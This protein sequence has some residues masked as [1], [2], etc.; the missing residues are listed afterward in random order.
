MKPTLTTIVIVTLMGCAPTSEVSGGGTG[1]EAPPPST[2]GT[3]DGGGG[4]TM[5]SMELLDSDG[6]GAP[7][8]VEELAGTDPS[9]AIDNPF[10]NGDF[11]FHVPL[12]GDPVPAVDTVVM[13]TSITEADVYFLIDTSWSMQAEIDG[14]RDGLEGTIMPGLLEQIPDVQLGAGEFDICP[15]QTGLHGSL[16]VDCAGIGNGQSITSDVDSVRSALND[17]TANC[18]I[19][20]PYGQGVYL[21]ATGDTSRW[22]TLA[23]RDCPYGPD[24]R[25]YVGYPCVRPDALPIL[26]VIGD[27]GYREG[28][29]CATDAP[30][31]FVPTVGAI[32]DA[33][34]AI[35]G[36][37]IVIGHTAASTQW[38][39]IAL[40]TGSVDA[41]GAPLLF[42][43][44]DGGSHIGTEIVDA[45]TTLAN[46]IPLDVSARV[47]DL[48]DDDV[49][50]TIFVDRV[51]PNTVG[52]EED[53]RGTGLVC[54]GGLM[55][56]GDTFVAVPPGT[57]VCFDIYPEVNETVNGG[58]FRASLEIVGEGV[59]VLDTRT[60]YFIVG[61][62]VDVPY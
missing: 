10:A 43:A 37:L 12:H 53:P 52:G 5:G 1:R 31:A 42:P 60:I 22:P 61:P 7:D 50:A 39:D 38:T 41:T 32:T 58:I 28:E 33:M 27:E 8:A 19:R 17:M 55:T 23:P 2:T 18:G 46:Q 26:V 11:V 30:G 3:P 47:R 40:G 44:S 9:S 48:D 13:G 56:S 45:V 51:V 4:G 54:V 21:F 14:V 34:N 35:G 29:R 62:A 49:D 59:T 36:K 16:Q 15:E 6:D 57:P 25:P 20:E 24:E